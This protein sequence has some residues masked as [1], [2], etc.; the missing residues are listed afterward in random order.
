MLTTLGMLIFNDNKIP[1]L[2]FIVG[3]IVTMLL[4]LIT[5]NYLNARVQFGKHKGS[6]WKSLPD[7]YLSWIVRN[8]K[9]N[10]AVE[11]AKSVLDAYKPKALSEDE[12]AIIK[13]YGDDFEKE[14]GNYY[15]FQGYTVEYRGLELG[16]K[17][18]GIDLIATKPDELVLIQCKY[19][20]KENSITQKMVKE[21][22]GSCHFYLD[23]TKTTVKPTCI[24][25]VATRDSISYG[26]N[27]LFKNNYMRC[28]YQVF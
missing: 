26:A 23:E 10:Y 11:K 16:L 21:F 13:Q 15:E 4:Y 18:G 1:S 2:E 17:D 9:S 24:Y 7:D 5:S 22:Y 25:A 8:H 6:K 20:K 27:Q 14:V 28:R 12:L 19:W 3:A